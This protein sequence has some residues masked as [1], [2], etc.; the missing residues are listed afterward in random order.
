[1][2][3]IHLKFNLREFEAWSKKS[4]GLSLETFV[5]DVVHF[6]KTM[7]EVPPMRLD[8]ILRPLIV[9]EGVAADDLVL[10]VVDEET[11][12]EYRY[13]PHPALHAVFDDR[14]SDQ[15]QA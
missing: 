7:E 11:G 12:K 15:P 3:P 13:N 8:R 1:M 14:S 9:D 4:T 2:T 10:T 5:G 6:L